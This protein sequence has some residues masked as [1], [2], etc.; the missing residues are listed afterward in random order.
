M[1]LLNTAFPDGP[2]IFLVPGRNTGI[3]G[4]QLFTL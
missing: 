4:V 1:V 3:L 2:V